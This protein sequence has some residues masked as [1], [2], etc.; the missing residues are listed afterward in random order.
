MICFISYKDNHLLCGTYLE[1]ISVTPFSLCY[2]IKTWLDLHSD[3]VA[4]VYCQNGRSRSGILIACFLKFISAFE[5]TSHAFDFFCSSRAQVEMKAS[6]APSYR[7]LFENM[8]KVVD[9]NLFTTSLNKPI[10]LKT[11]AISGLPVDE[12]PCIE[13]WDL[14]G[15]VYISHQN[16]KVKNTAE[17]SWSSEYGDGIFR[18]GADVLGDFSIMVRFGGAHAIKRDKT[19]IIFK[20]HNHTCVLLPEVMELRKQNVDV[21]PEYDDSLD[22]ELF[23][24]HLMFE[25]SSQSKV[26]FI[27]KEGSS[28]MQTQAKPKTW[29]Q[30]TFEAGLDEISKLHSDVPDAEKHAE[31]LRMG[32]PQSYATVALQLSSNN[33]DHAA[34]LVDLMRARAGEF[35]SP[36]NMN[37]ISQAAARSAIWSPAEGMNTWNVVG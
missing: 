23:S 6:L 11:L 30:N 16:F 21:N 36:S 8:D 7:I 35:S 9:Q 5:T 12:I 3:H 20:Y 4:V 22:V 2:S 31:L 32:Y 34:S 26:D 14:T 13:I 18:I 37:I 17:N 25:A 15:Q 1:R 19:T 24:A 33:L 29:N 10:H 28:L 27:Q